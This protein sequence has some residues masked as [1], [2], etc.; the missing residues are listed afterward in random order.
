MRCQ[1]PSELQPH[2]IDSLER[3]A[4]AV[5]QRHVKHLLHGLVGQCR[6]AHLLRPRVRACLESRLTDEL[7]HLVG[8]L[9]IVIIGQVMLGSISLP[10][11]VQ[12]EIN[13]AHQARMCS[14]ARADT[15]NTLRETLDAQPSRAWEK[16]IELEAVEAMARSG[17]PHFF[18][19][20]AR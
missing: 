9:G 1:A 8:R 13:L 5:L 2:L 12:A 15:L 18:P 3:S 20:S 7:P 11:T 19:Y 4:S 6:T 16:V 10:E 17:A 14:K